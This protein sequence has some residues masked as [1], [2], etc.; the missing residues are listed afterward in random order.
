MLPKSL[1]IGLAFVAAVVSVALLSS[2]LSDDAS[3]DGFA[4]LLLAWTALP[5]ALLGWLAR[6]AD[7]DFW[8]GLLSV[9]AIA[10]GVLWL[11]VYRSTAVASPDAPGGVVFI[12]LPLLQLAVVLGLWILYFVS[13]WAER[14]ANRH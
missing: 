13:R 14:A 12:A 11:A 7:G 3:R 10:L 4:L 6:T 8:T 5:C 2:R 1:P 9:T